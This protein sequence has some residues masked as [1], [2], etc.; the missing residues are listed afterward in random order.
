[1]RRSALS[2]RSSLSAP[3]FKALGL[4]SADGFLAD[5]GLRIVVPAGGQTVFL[6]E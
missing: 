6:K 3:M 2:G 4:P 5:G 1:M